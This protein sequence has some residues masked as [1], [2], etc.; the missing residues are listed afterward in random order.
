MIPRLKLKWAFGFPGVSSARSQPSILGNRLFVGSESGDIFALDAKTGCTYWTFHTKAGHSNG[1]HR[2][3]PTSARTGRT[4]SPST[5]RMVAPTSYAVDSETGQEI[6]SRHMDNHVYAKS[7]GSLTYHD[8]RVY[9]PVAGVG[10]EGQGGSSKYE[11]CTFRGSLSALDANTGAVIWKTYTMDEP[12]PR[13]KSKDGVQLWGPAGAGIWAAPTV[14]AQRRALYVATGNAY[15]EPNSK[16]SD[17]VVAFDMNDAVKIKWTYQPTQDVWVGGCKRGDENPNCPA[18]ARTRPRL[19]DVAGARQ[20]HQRLRHPHRPAEIRHGVR[21]RSRQGGST[22]VAVPDERRR[23]PRWSVGRGDRR[24]AGVLQR[25][26]SGQDGRRVAR[27]Q[28]GH[29]RGRVDEGRRAAAV[30]H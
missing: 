24:A 11:C 20:A 9:V 28:R 30:R 4:G 13:G 7:T 19:L 26:R 25:Q 27:G 17:A 10:E 18:D 6:W 21:A 22:R 1:D 12:K 5:S 15:A 2:S 3:V 23:W 29:R 8:G 14:D 16:T